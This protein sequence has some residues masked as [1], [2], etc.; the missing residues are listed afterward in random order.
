MSEWS[1]PHEGLT[2]THA[3]QRATRNSRRYPPD[4]TRK[5]LPK[6]RT[7]P[8]R[9]GALL[10]TPQKAT[11]VVYDFGLDFTRGPKPGWSAGIPSCRAGQ[12]LARF[13]L[14][15]GEDIWPSLNFLIANLGRG[16]H[17]AG[18]A[19]AFSNGVRYHAG[20]VWHSHMAKQSQARESECVGGI[21]QQI[22]T[23]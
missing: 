22:I 7:T 2:E 3:G 1:D 14:R 11:P 17:L 21:A 20:W 4:F 9:G 10:V 18:I 8:Q 12:N 16:H 6:S 23:K 15:E 5:S 19:T 13:S